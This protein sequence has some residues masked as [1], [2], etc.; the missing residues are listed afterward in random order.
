M[1][2]E[3]DE[4]SSIFFLKEGAVGFVLPRHHNIKYC[5]FP[6]GSHFGIMDIISSC[7]D[8]NLEIDDWQMHLDKMK[9]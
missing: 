1:Y 8:N 5:D 7:F 9:R 2:Q 4:I 3:G 6:E